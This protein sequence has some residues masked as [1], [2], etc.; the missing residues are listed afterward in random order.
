MI[1]TDRKGQYHYSMT[2]GD[3]IATTLTPLTFRKAAFNGTQFDFRSENLGATLL[4]SRVNAPL[5]QSLPLPAALTNTTDLTAGRVTASAGPVTFGAT[6]A[7]GHQSRASLE[8]FDGNPLKGHLT[9]AQASSTVGDITI[10]LSDDSPD[11]REGGAILYSERVVVEDLKGN[12]YDSAEI[13][14]RANRDGGL[15]VDGFPT[16]SGAERILLNYDLRRFAEVLPTTVDSLKEVRFEL[17]VGNDYL[18]E[19][20]SEVQ[21]NVKSQP[22]FLTVARAPGN[23]KDAS[24]RRVISFNYGLPTANQVAGLSMEISEVAGFSLYAE[25]VVNSRYRQLPNALLRTHSSSADRSTAW[26]V[27]AARN[28]WP[29]F[30]YGEAFGMDEDYSTSFYLTDPTGQVDYGDPERY[31][32]DF[33]DDNDDL[34]R[35]PDQKRAFQ[36]TRQVVAGRTLGSPREGQPD[37]AVFPGW[38]ENGD[39]IS[40]FNQNDN[41][42]RP[43]AIPDFEGTLSALQRRPAGVSVRHRPEQQRLDR[44]F[45]GRRRSGLPIQAR[46]PGVQLLRRLQLLQRSAGP[47]GKLPPENLL[48]RPPQ[49]GQ[50]RDVHRRQ[51]VSP[52]RQGPLLRARQEGEGRHPRSADRPS[53]VP[54]GSPGHGAGPPAGDRRLGEHRL[55]RVR[56]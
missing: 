28:T 41:P 24:N 36:G 37:Q 6:L 15:I 11:D 46:P 18:V 35:W 3:E 14:F 20:A 9:T 34:D 13:G 22:V 47:A 26:M 12:R 49:L 38:D 45:R 19:I 50:L 53:G 29:W 56:R 52:R 40:D 33:V 4:L 42:V 7:N 21:T 17:Q 27:N 44:P 16:A 25:Y 31:L 2:I 55:A 39:F 32:F 54:R 48:V 1:S 5:V 8:R 30:V 10:R 43:N 51:A 23:I